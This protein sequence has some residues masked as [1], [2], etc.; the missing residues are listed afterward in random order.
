MRIA[1]EGEFIDVQ[2]ETKK[3]IFCRKSMRFYGYDYGGK[4]SIFSQ[5]D[6]KVVFKVAGH[7][8]WYCLGTT[9]YYPPMLMIG[10]LYENVF[11]QYYEINYTR[12]YA[13]KAKEKSLEL[14]ESITI[15]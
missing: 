15:F 11:T 2:E 3:H 9:K 12:K 8:G 1:N 7:S 4:I 6:G 10:T 13:K 5:K 14:L